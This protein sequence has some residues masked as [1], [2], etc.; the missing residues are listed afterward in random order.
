MTTLSVWLLLITVSS[1]GTDFRNQTASF[2]GDVAGERGVVRVIVINNTDFRPVMTFGAYDQLD[3]ERAPD[4]VQIRLDDGVVTLDPDG[5]TPILGVNC[6]R[7]FSIGGEELLRRIEESGTA[8]LD[9]FALVTGVQFFAP[10]DENEPDG[11]PELVG[12]A[13]PF[14]GLLGVDFPCGAQLIFRL[15]INDPGP[16]PFRIDFELIPSD[17]T[18]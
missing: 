18:R 1:C 16:E 2:G 15:E 7:I 9:E 8:D 6:G 11:E 5:Q 13:A 4:V 10:V 17:S 14:D 12:S 3:R